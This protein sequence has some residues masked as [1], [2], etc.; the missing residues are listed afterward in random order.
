MSIFVEKKE[1]A[2]SKICKLL[3]Q[4]PSNSY[5]TIRQIL[6]LRNQSNIKTSKKRKYNDEFILQRAE[7]YW[8]INI[9]KK[10]NR[11]K[12]KIKNPQRLIRQTLKINSDD[13]VRSF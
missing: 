10:K 12:K 4:T 9:I 8:N 11:K 5:E 7:F 1:I 13:R 2:I 6:I 3:N